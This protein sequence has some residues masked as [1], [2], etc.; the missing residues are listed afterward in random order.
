[1]QRRAQ[2]Y[3][4]DL[5]LNEKELQAKLENLEKQIR[6]KQART[7]VPADSNQYGAS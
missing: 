3:L 6:E 4:S 2:E 5:E 1:L 7:T